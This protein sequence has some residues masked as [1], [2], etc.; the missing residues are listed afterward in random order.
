MLVAIFLLSLLL[1]QA[2]AE[3][4]RDSFPEDNCLGQYLKRSALWHIFFGDN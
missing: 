2:V 1:S 3:C 4:S